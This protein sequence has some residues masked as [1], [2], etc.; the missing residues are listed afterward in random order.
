MLCQEIDTREAA[1]AR[2][3]VTKDEFV[4]HQTECSEWLTES[5]SGA[6]TDTAS[7]HRALRQSQAQVRFLEESLKEVRQTLNQS[8]ASSVAGDDVA[9]KNVANETGQSTKCDWQ[10]MRGG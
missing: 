5:E 7:M 3:Y 1:M 6:T 4:K 10:C 9:E 8:G 2:L